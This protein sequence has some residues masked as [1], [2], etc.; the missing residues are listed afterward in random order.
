[1][2]CNKLYNLHTDF[3]AVSK[4][5]SPQLIFLNLGAIWT[6]ENVNAHKKVNKKR[7]KNVNLPDWDCTV[8]QVSGCTAAEIKICI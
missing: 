3:Q 8:C 2:R 4:T 7:K 5:P 6:K 1:M